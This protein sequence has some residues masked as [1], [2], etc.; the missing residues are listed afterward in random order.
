MEINWRSKRILKEIYLFKEAFP[1]T[2][3]KHKNS[4]VVITQANFK[5]IIKL[6]SDWPFNPPLVLVNYNNYEFYQPTIADW[7]LIMDIR[8]I[9]Y[10]VM[11]TINNNSYKNLERIE[12]KVTNISI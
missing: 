7:N 1:C 6:A 3:I 2:N 5:C 10:D 8:T 4:I 11:N 12:N 9:F